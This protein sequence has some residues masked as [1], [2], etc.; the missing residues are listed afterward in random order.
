MSKL[1]SPRCVIIAGPNGAG[2]TT[3]AREFLPKDTDV[4]HFVNA[5]LIAAGLSA[6]KPEIAA[7]TAGRVFLA[8]SRAMSSCGASAVVGPTLFGSTAR[9]R[10]PGR[11]MII[12]EWNR[13]CWSKDHDTKTP[14]GTTEAQ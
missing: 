12:P 2:K 7:V 8:D 4:V 3:F 13:N 10:T 1:T 11:C 9:W 14:S 6:L 5:D